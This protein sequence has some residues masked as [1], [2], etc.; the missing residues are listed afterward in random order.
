MALSTLILLV[1]LIGW[2]YGVLITQEAECHSFEIVFH[3]AVMNLLFSSVAYMFLP[4]KRPAS[5]MY[6]SFIWIGVFL[7]IAEICFTAALNLAE[8]IAL[9]NVT[10]FFVVI[11]GYG[12][13]I[14]R[15]G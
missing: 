3:F 10:A 5:E 1:S 13:S 15:Y 8:N 14:L 12:I 2:S 11:F 9:T 4:D 7:L 6:E